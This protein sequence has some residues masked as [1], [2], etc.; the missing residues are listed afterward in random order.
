MTKNDKRIK[1]KFLGENKGISENTNE[2]IKMATGKYISLL[3]H[4]D[5][6]NISALY[7][8]VKAI[9]ENKDVD[10]IYSD[11][12]KFHFLDAPYY[13]PHFKPDF[14]P[15]TLRANNYICH[16]SVFKKELIDK[17]GGFNHDF[18]GAQDFDMILRA[19][20]NAKNIVHISKVL[21]HWRVH[22]NSTAMQTEAKP[23][24]IE[25]GRRAVEAHLARI[26]LKGKVTNGVNPGTY[27]I[28]YDVIGN[29]KV[30]ILIPNK[31]GID[32]LEKCIESI[33]SK[34][35]YSNYEIVIIENNS[36][37]EKTFDYYNEIIKNSKIK[38]LNYNKNTLLDN[39]GEKE[40][41]FKDNSEDK[42]NF[43]YSKLINFGVRNS[44]GDF[45]VQLNY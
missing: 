37:D 19:T 2:A 35:T 24:A 41:E 11:E 14:A 45:I 1:Y 44:N 23:Y 16:Y 15:D 43:N 27:Q 18:D 31:D 21:Y 26:G 8:V 39:Q 13:E 7:E 22:K 38:V 42:Q 9:N 25:A 34:T 5:M 36:S 32:L 20:E 40:V 17:I 30:S 28:E 10:F 4:D 3:D 6:L 33:I 12:D 29:P